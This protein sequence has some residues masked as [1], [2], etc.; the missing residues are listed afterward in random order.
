MN[1]IF[2]TKSSKCKCCQNSSQEKVDGFKKQKGAFFL[3]LLM[4]W[5]YFRMYL[6]FLFFHNSFCLSRH[7]IYTFT[8]GRIHLQSH[9]PQ[10]KFNLHHATSCLWVQNCRSLLHFVIDS[11][12]EASPDSSRGSACH[13]SFCPFCPHQYEQPNSRFFHQNY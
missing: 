3:R 9:I 4:L 5:S 2:L 10:S 7:R 6:L 1:F 11:R 13:S 8:W 12:F